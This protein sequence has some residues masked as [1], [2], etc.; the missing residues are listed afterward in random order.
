MTLNP[1]WSPEVGFSL[2]M[3]KAGEDQLAGGAPFSARDTG[4]KIEPETER[5]ESQN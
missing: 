5:G 4:A 3:Q 2:A 1:P